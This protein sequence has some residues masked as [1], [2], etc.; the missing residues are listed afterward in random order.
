MNFIEVSSV[1]KKFGSTLVLDKIN[2][3]LEKG[4]FVVLEGKNGSGKTSLINSILGLL[5]V[6]KG[7]ITL[8]NKSPKNHQVKRNIGVVFQKIKFPEHLKVKELVNLWRSYYDESRKTEEILKEMNL[9]D[10]ANDFVS[11]L[12]GGQEKLLALALALLGNPKL[13]I[14]DEPTAFLGQDTRGI[15]WQQIKKCKEEGVTI[16]MTTHQNDDWEY[17][18]ELATRKIIL[19]NGKIQE[20]IQINSLEIQQE[21]LKNLH[22]EIKKI[23]YFF[24]FFNQSRIELR[25]LSHNLQYLVGIFILPVTLIALW[26]FS[27]AGKS[28][29]NKVAVMLAISFLGL[30][31]YAIERLGKSISLERIGGWIKLLRV[32]PLPP[33]IY[34]LSKL[35][36]VLIISSI[37]LLFIFGFGYLKLGIE[38][39]FLTWITIFLSLVLGIM[40]FAI[41]GIGIGYLLNPKSIDVFL[42][43]SLFVISLT[44]GLPLS[45]SE[46]Y[47][48]I[49]IFSPFYHYKEL[50]TWSA[51]FDR[52]PVDYLG[53][54]IFWLIWTG[55]L[56]SFVTVWAYKRDKIV[57]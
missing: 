8:L 49:L 18:K 50:L 34:L 33:Y 5:D 37:S 54:H 15:F 42:G 29:D 27:A 16:L 22:E 13:L 28:N 57:Q 2:L 20:D 14:L 31:I 35:T 45:E 32:S 3:T 39:Q 24:L 52:Y 36:L 26:W 21:K 23:N 6:N 11:K 25:Q 7:K 51:H 43:L 46:M 17:L 55:I 9:E 41:L 10:K 19:S 1:S 56:L 53:L 12:S 4:E 38:E 40:P 47:E 44:C 30:M 48:N